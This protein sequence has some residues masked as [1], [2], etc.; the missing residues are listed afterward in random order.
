M[1]AQ[2]TGNATVNKQTEVIVQPSCEDEYDPA[3]LPVDVA[4]ARIAE[5]ITPISDIEWVPVRQLMCPTTP[6]LRW[7]GML[8]LHLIF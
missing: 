6:I 7:M 4:L 2:E 5:A 3:L 1:A 8:W